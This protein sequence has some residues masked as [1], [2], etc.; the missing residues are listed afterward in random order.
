MPTASSKSIPGPEARAGA[1]AGR[2][3]PRLFPC[4]L[5]LVTAES[6]G[7]LIPLL[8]E[9]LDYLDRPEPARLHDLAFTFSRSY[10]PGAECLAIVASSHEDLRTKIVRALEQ[11]ADDRCARIHHRDGIYYYR[12]RLGGEKVAF[13]FP[14]ENAQYVN[15]LAELCLH[16][17][18]IRGAFDEADAACA[19]AGD[20]FLPSAL[21]FPAPGSNGTG[22]HGKDEISEWEKAVVLVHTANAA[23]TRLLRGLQ[24]R[25][26]AVLGHSFGELSALEMAG[27]LRPGEGAERVRF[28][29]HAYLHLRE[30]SQERDLPRGRLL[31]VG[32]AERAQID[33]ILARFPDSLR[34]AMENCP[35]QYV[36]CASGPETDTAIVEAEKW[37]AAEGAI[38]VPL[39]IRRPYHTPFFEPAFPFE[40]AYYE[41]VGVQP[42]EIEVYSCSTTE[43]FPSEPEAIV[44]VAA[45]HWMS[46][47]RFQETIEKMY[48]RGFRVFV[49]VGPR[50]N[51]CAF[52]GDI[53]SGKPHLTVAL[54]RPTRS[55]TEQLLNA[56]G[57]L[58]A[59]GV[60]LNV[61]HLHERW[62]SR[63]V[64][65][66][67]A[68][69]P[70]R[71]SMALQLPIY[72]PPMKAE[73]IFISRPAP[74]ERAT[75]HESVA[76][77]TESV[78]SRG[79]AMAPPVVPSQQNAVDAVMIS[80]MDTM[81]RFLSVQGEIL[82]SLMHAGVRQEHAEDTSQGKL[83]SR[84]FPLL[85]SIREKIP[86]RSLTARR[87]FDVQE[88]LYLNDHALGTR[89]STT[90]AALRA[91]P[92]MPLL[93][94]VEMAAEAGAAL[95]PDRKVI[96][97][98]GTRAHR[99]IF[100]DKGM[101]T[102]RAVARRVERPGDDVHVHVIIQQENDGDPTLFPTMA[103]TTVVLAEAYPAPPRSGMQSLPPSA[104]CDWTG[105]DIYP[106][107]TF[108][109]PLFQGI[110]SIT[111]HSEEG[112]DGTLEVLPSSGLIR[113][114]PDAELETDPLLSDCLGQSAWLWGSREPFAGLAYLPYSVDALRFY[115][116]A[117]PP[118]TP[119]DL[120]LRVRKREPL[121]VTMDIEGVDSLGNVR[122][123]LEGLADREFPITPALHR[124]IMEPLD[125]YFADVQSLELAIPDR[126]ATRISFSTVA[127]FPQAVLEGSLGVWRKALAFLILSPQEREEWMGLD[128]PLR[129]Q[130]HWLLGRAA[131]KDALRHHLQQSAGLRFAAADLMIRAEDTGRP[132]LDG[133][134][135]AKLSGKP[136]ISISHT[137]GMVA[138]VAATVQEGT[139]VGVDTEKIC[140]PSQ[141][142]LDGA[143]SDADL[144]LLPSAT[145]E[146]ESQR[147]EWI[148]RFWCAKEAVGKAL[149]S[150]VSLDPRQFAVSRADAESGMVAVRPQGGGEVLAAT[151][152][153]D[154]HVFAVAVLRTT[155]SR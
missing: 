92:V 90:D 96:A 47:V 49:D 17:P 106:R 109:G 107:R 111:R 113:S 28:A 74:A 40:K 36:L 129:R 78:A 138:A 83:A 132:V 124:L 27:V 13:L 11:L 153:R 58:A 37:L 130:I 64:D 95:F 60:P 25:P 57:I 86:A 31:A 145:R 120:K 43:P 72:L 21:N 24:M 79:A 150:G 42:P 97:F 141:D 80:Y 128:V 66:R 110:R 52:V 22:R 102:L 84:R 46:C 69:G 148:F 62:G 3:L 51:L 98:V 131:A 126:G 82:G 123:A 68:K 112:L 53:L 7:D 45:R 59:H 152:R 117:L 103:E 4:E 67:A 50:G 54:N 20:G 151:F 19:M 85:G 15:M 127:G 14:G 30:L 10:E 125:H 18:E 143:F 146:S 94:S 65:I 135:R 108:H 35:R 39:P 44:E 116:S 8:T 34:V 5:F 70:G 140:T 23:F 89:L 104:A 139:R 71:K 63:V 147:S 93:F 29:H 91:L 1:P 38:C 99:W 56:L 154:Q 75:P 136:E 81:E 133:I 6:R 26:D 118:G 121:S 144:A 77:A 33:A 142:L 48:D 32:G 41:Q 16:F 88:D 115:G 105:T 9:L 2:R 61:G 87:V 137:D 114:Q 55:D 155:G 100:L 122:L 76:A 149:G 119:L 101:V 134:W 73:G 12:E